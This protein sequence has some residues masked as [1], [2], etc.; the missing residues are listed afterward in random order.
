[1]K[2][3]TVRYTVVIR[4]I[5]LARGSIRVKGETKAQAAGLAAAYLMRRGL[6]FSGRMTS[7]R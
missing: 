1:M 3:Y 5:V 7:I 4:G 6:G 2:A